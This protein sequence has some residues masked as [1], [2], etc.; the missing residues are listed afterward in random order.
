M[1]LQRVRGAKLTRTVTLHVSRGAQRGFAQLLLKGTSADTSGEPSD[2]ELAIVLGFDP[3]GGG[4]AGRPRSIAD[5]AHAIAQ[6]HRYDGV[7][8]ELRGGRGIESR[9]RVFRDP[10]LRV[11]GTARL[12]V[13]IRG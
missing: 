1:L 6:I 8:A 3:G 9:R 13:R 5:L 7:T 2:S 10:D 4:S 12:F 11:S